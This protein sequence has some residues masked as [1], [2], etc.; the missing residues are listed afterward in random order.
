MLPEISLDTL[1]FEEIVK[2]ARSQIAEIYPQWTDYNYHDPG[3][4]ILELFAF[5]KEAQQFYIDQTSDSMRKKFLQLMGIT[6][7]KR[8]A[9]YTTARFITDHALTIPMG[10]KF[11][12][13]GL[14][15]EAMQLENIPGNIIKAVLVR[16]KF[17]PVFQSRITNV[18]K[19]GN[20]VLYPFGKQ[21][22]VGS[23]FDI[24]LNKSL[25]KGKRYR[26]SISLDDH[27][28][29]ERNPIE[30]PSSFV[31]LSQIRISYFDGK[32]D[33]EIKAEDG[34]LGFIRSGE[35]V[36]SIANDIA[37][38]EVEG[39][40]GY[41]INFYLTQD[42]FD[43]SPA[44]TEISFQDIPLVQK[45]TK[46]VFLDAGQA[47][48]W[49]TD[50][51]KA[52]Y[53]GWNEDNGCFIDTTPEMA[54]KTAIYEQDFYEERILAIGNGLPDQRYELKQKGI[55]ADSFEILVSS[56][57]YEGYFRQWIKVEDFDASGPD[58]CH[59]VVDEENNCIFF[60]NG[61]KGRMPEAEIRIVSCG[62]SAGN[63]GNIK[64]GQ[65]IEVPP[66]FSQVQG[67]HIQDA[68]GGMEPEKLEESFAR[69][70]K[71][72]HEDERAISASDY[73]KLIMQTPGLRI[74]DCKV[75]DASGFHDAPYANEVR[76]VVR[77]FSEN[78]YAPLSYAYQKNIYNRI[79]KRRLIGTR[80]KLYSPIYIEAE[81]YT[82]L[83]IKP[84]FLHAEKSVE[85]A[86]RQF[87][88]ALK[89]FGSVISYSSLFACIDG[90]E[91]V[92]EIYMLY[93][94]ARG[95]R[96]TRS[97]NGDVVLPPL[98]VLL[99]KKVDCIVIR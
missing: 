8:H 13:N 31:P 63:G 35:I 90:L 86:V 98:G 62:F 30:D 37:L 15:F 78:G 25:E 4:T 66:A 29:V 93:V 89:G 9:A 2:K 26:L 36:F 68:W 48:A 77:P 45:D 17:G 12:M 96:I 39:I 82:E 95:G 11:Y 7:M 23:Q 33:V 38:T 16:P 49:K 1:G 81:V 3:I 71:T 41:Y 79:M 55:L 88:S 72:L 19:H 64:I 60:G 32:N 50:H 24:C 28:L 70:R 84:Q 10:C 54:V 21:T 73:E 20:M 76:V 75:L 99:L 58:D 34:T 74:W 40:E 46:A 69:A 57:K 87:F 47:T 52:D 67:E 80:V 91:E 51:V 6:P 92:L 14:C 85:K 83:R 27:Y 59:Y 97:R 44:I 43:V 61:I 94:D 5:L 18:E 53:Y 42:A 65:S 56:M 22:G